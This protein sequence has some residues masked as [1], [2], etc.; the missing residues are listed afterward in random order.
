MFELLSFELL[1]VNVLFFAVR[2][3]LG[4]TPHA[5]NPGIASCV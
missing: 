4:L 2:C 1:G 3:E 5:G